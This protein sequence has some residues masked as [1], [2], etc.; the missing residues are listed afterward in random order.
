[1]ELFNDV[2]KIGKIILGKAENIN[3][4]AVSNIKESDRFEACK[5]EILDSIVQSCKISDKNATTI[6]N[7]KTGFKNSKIF[8]FLDCVKETNAIYRMTRDNYNDNSNDNFGYL[9][10]IE[11]MKIDTS[12]IKDGK[13]YSNM[14]IIYFDFYLKGFSDSLIDKSSIEKYGNDFYNTN[15]GRGIKYLS[16]EINIKDVLK[17]ANKNNNGNNESDN[18]ITFYF[19]NNNDS[20]FANKPFESIS[21]D[22]NRDILSGKNLNDNFN[23][24]R[25]N[26]ALD[27]LLSNEFLNLKFKLEVLNNNF[28]HGYSNIGSINIDLLYRMVEDK[29]IKPNEIIINGEDVEGNYSNLYSILFDLKNNRKVKI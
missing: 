22:L 2:L 11:N 28:I 6:E 26:V 24:Y 12:D 1:M 13:S 25:N 17:M 15:S 8:E 3:N 5:K 16:I 29:F 9:V 27:R 21:N 7:I 4:T 23:L 18:N 10:D 20:F 14:V 19:E